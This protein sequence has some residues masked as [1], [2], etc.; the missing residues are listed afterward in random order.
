MIRGTENWMMDFYMTEENLV[1][2]LLDYCTEASA[3][4]IK[5]MVQ[6]GCDMVSNGDSPAGPEMIPADLYQK[7]AKPYAKKMVDIA[8][9]AG[10]DYVLHICGNTDIIIDH[11]IETGADGLELDH[12]TNIEIAFNLMKDKCT[13]FGNVDPSGVLALGAPDLVRKKT[14]ELLDIFSKTNRFVLNSGCALPS[15]TPAE[16]IE[17]FINTAREYK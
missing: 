4:F 9:D 2:E 6:T 17:M 13:L 5:L 3:Q 11:M 8:H 10:V 12:K 16:N 15:T 1:F 14:L 7:F